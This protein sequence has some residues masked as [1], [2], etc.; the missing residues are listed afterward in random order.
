M[1]DC[2]SRRLAGWAVADHMRTELVEDALKAAAATRSSLKD[3]IFHS[4]HG[5]VGE[6]NWLSQHLDHGGVQRWRRRTG[7]GRAAMCPRARVGSGVL[8][9]R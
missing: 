5:S 7:A 2:Y 3:A 1:I 8:I 9:G 6:I 4:D